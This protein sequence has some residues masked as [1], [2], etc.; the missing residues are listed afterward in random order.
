M[1][2]LG[3]LATAVFTTAAPKCTVTYLQNPICISSPFILAVV[4]NQNHNN[5]LNCRRFGGGG[6]IQTQRRFISAFAQTSGG[7]RCGSSGFDDD[8]NSTKALPLELVKVT[9]LK[10]GH[11]NVIYSSSNKQAGN[12]DFRKSSR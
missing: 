11:I 2:S 4:G 3:R 5:D 8:N 10:V 1:R 12:N 6:G 7:D 9:I